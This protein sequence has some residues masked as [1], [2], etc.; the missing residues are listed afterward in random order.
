M[1]GHEQ[2]QDKQRM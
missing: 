1:G 2:K